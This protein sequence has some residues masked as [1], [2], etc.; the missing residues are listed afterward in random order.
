MNLGEA[1][2]LSLEALKAKDYKLAIE[3]LS[4]AIQKNELDPSLYTLLS[5][6]YRKSNKTGLAIKVLELAQSIIGDNELILREHTI[7]CE[8]E[9]QNEKAINS[10]NK[11]FKLKS[12]I[13]LLRTALSEVNLKLSQLQALFEKQRNTIFPWALGSDFSGKIISIPISPLR[14]CNAPVC[15]VSLNLTLPSPT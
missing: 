11:L 15:N 4:K 3:M 8:I 10:I 1:K 2:K 14:L 5:I 13:N 12:Q 6:A 7:C 9:K